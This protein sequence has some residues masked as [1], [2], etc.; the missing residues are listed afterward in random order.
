MA[1]Q[2]EVDAVPDSWV[3][4]DV[5]E[6]D[7]LVDIGPSKKPVTHLR[8][9]DGPLVV[10]E[11]RIRRNGGSQ[12]FQTERVT[13]LHQVEVDAGSPRRKEP[14]GADAVARPVGLDPATTG[15]MSV[16]RASSSHR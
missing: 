16:P 8:S 13:V 6:T 4:H 12:R 2:I 10:A 15:E 1:G 3:A 9:V 7:V 14:P 11:H 5:K